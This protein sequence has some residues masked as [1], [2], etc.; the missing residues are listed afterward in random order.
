MLEWLDRDP[1]NGL[2]ITIAF[3]ISVIIGRYLRNEKDRTGGK[4]DTRIKILVS[5]LLIIV[6]TLMEH[7]YFPLLIVAFCSGMALKKKVVR[8]YSKMLVFPVV[9]AL[10]IM[11]VQ[12]FNFDANSNGW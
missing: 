4:I 10:F 1:L 12:G 11:A 2:V 9:L 3:F 5:F 8:R 7:W 6:L